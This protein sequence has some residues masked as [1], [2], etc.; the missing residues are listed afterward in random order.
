VV[1][2]DAYNISQY[3]PNQLGS[4][5]N[6]STSA[7]LIPLFMRLRHEKDEKALGRLPMQL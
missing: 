1:F 5:L 7:G 3:I 6:A 2:R 4:L